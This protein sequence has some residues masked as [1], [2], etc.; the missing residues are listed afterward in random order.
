M[1][2][3][4]FFKELMTEF[5]VLAVAADAFFG[6][7]NRDMRIAFYRTKQAASQE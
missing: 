1:V 5:D 2:L 7:V 3:S 4:Q 6:I